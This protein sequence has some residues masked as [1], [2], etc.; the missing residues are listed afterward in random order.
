MSSIIAAEPFN[1]NNFWQQTPKA[2]KYFI[3]IALVIAGSY[4]MFSKS[5]TITQIKQIDK[6]EESINT[7]YSLI[8]QFQEFE[9]KQFDYNIQTMTYLKNIYSLVE[10]LNDNANKKFDMILKGQGSNTNQIIEKLT[11]LNE[12]FEKLH[13]AYSPKEELKVP[14]IPESKV[15]ITKIN[16]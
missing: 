7:T 3:I 5:M 16:K 4:F 6:I 9:K 15:V 11:L 13:K 1:I 10:E 2:L 14:E 12:S 8:N